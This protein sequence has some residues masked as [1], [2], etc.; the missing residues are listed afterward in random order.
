MDDILEGG[1]VTAGM[2]S[3]NHHLAVVLFDSGSSHS[4]I[5]QAFARKYEQKIVEL[6]CA[7]R[8]SLARADLLTNQVVQG[9]T[10]GISDRQ[11][12]VN[13]IVMPSLVLDVI[14]G[15]N[16]MNKMSVVID[17]RNRT[18]SLKEPVGE[19]TFQVVL[20]RRIDLASTTCAVQT[21]L[22]TKIP[23]VC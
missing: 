8:I 2:F 3:I 5:S 10:L 11:Y 7:Y 18:I 22:L 1:P 19:G 6:E 17:A 14:I 16:W 12:S 15:M 4:F 23:V 20:P 13:L 9:A 21:T